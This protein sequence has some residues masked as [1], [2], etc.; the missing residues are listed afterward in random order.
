MLL[1][2]VLNNNPLSFLSGPARQKPHWRHGLTTCEPWPLKLNVVATIYPSGR[3]EV[4]T[5][6]P[7][8]AFLARTPGK[9]SL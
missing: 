6:V 8:Q 4:C 2:K 3:I 5:T 9:I 7:L 1:S